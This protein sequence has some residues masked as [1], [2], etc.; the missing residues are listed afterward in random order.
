MLNQKRYE[1]MT[2]SEAKKV[3]KLREIIKSSKI[4]SRKVDENLLLATFN[5]REFGNTAH[6]RKRRV[7]H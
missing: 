2:K 6:R 1:K 4:P 3:K 5:I 7:E